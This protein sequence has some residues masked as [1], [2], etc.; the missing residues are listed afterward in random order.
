MKSFE[1]P[2]LTQRG[3]I[4]E[5]DEC[6]SLWIERMEIFDILDGLLPEQIQQIAKSLAALEG[7]DFFLEVLGGGGSGEQNDRRYHH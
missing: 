5:N 1:A 7:D 6:D 3:W 2:Y 4:A